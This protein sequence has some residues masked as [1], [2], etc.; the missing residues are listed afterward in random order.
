M[1]TVRDPDRWYASAGDTILRL[2]PPRAADGSPLPL[3]PSVVERRK[4]LDPLVDAVLFRGTFEGLAADRDFAT[5]VFAR[6]NAAVQA[7]VPADRLLVY[8][9]GQ[10]WEP[11]CRF[12]GVAAPEGEPFPRVNDTAAF[13]AGVPSLP[14]AAPEGAAS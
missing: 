1:L 5:G 10:G 7:E 3:A 13:R 8:E 2:N 4:L 11:L 14:S 12:L 6:H 9:V